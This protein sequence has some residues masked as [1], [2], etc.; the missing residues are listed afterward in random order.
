[1]MMNELRVMMNELHVRLYTEEDTYYADIL[2]VAGRNNCCQRPGEGF[3]CRLEDTTPAIL[4]AQD[5]LLQLQ[6]GDGMMVLHPVSDKLYAFLFGA[7]RNALRAYWERCHADAAGQGGLRLVLHCDEDSPLMTV[8]WE[9]MRDR[10][11]DY[12]A[13]LNSPTRH[14]LVRTCWGPGTHK[15]V[16]LGQQEPLRVL[17]ALCSM[18][19]IIKAP[20]EA[21]QVDAAL[22][23]MLPW[24]VDMHVLILPSYADLRDWCRRWRPHVFHFVGHGDVQGEPVLLME[25]KPGSSDVAQTLSTSALADLFPQE[26]PQ[27]VILNACRSGQYIDITRAAQAVQSFTEVLTRRGVLAVISMQADIQG[28]A[29]ALLMRRFYAS[30]AAGE[31][32]DQALTN[33]RDAVKEAHLNAWD[34]ALPTLYVSANRQVEEVV[35]LNPARQQPGLCV[36][37]TSYTTPAWR[38]LPLS[39]PLSVQIRVGYDDRQLCL[40]ELFL[41]PNG[42]EKT[43]RLMLI[44]GPGDT[45]KTNLLFWL[46]ECCARRGRPFL[47]ADLA[48]K[49]LDYWDVLRLIRDGELPQRVPGGVHLDN[50]LQPAV[51]FNRFNDALNRKFI[52]NYTSLVPLLDDKTAVPDRTYDVDEASELARLGHVGAEPGGPVQALSDAFWADLLRLAEPRGLIIFLDNL[53]EDIVPGEANLLCEFLI[54]P[55]YDADRNVRLVLAHRLEESPVA[56]SPWEFSPDRYPAPSFE[57]YVLN[58]LPGDKISWLARVWARRYFLHHFLAPPVTGVW[59]LLQR[60]LE[61]TRPLPPRL[62]DAEVDQHI[63]DVLTFLEAEAGN[64]ALRPGDLVSTAVMEARVRS[65]FR[66]LRILQ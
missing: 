17:F 24:Q 52:A 44:S 7:K 16:P 36:F 63:K 53:P 62:T 50:G 2:E 30:L 58:G 34:W 25:P 15:A 9:L 11:Q 55:V 3:P 14:T 31:W 61:L 28:D 21:L 64:A 18:E 5:T 45:G 8:P 48:Y 19:E 41:N 54:N 29:A 46:A 13:L 35:W 26:V 49:A 23:Q 43:P 20:D 59:Q 27:L 4:T 39:L 47:Y 40:E 1:M 57:K 65:W 51:I 33:A 6:P 38:N 22:G 66:K 37:P 42:L 56:N 10:S 32:V 12:M 60:K